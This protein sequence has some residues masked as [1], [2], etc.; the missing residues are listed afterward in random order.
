MEVVSDMQAYGIYKRLKEL[1]K[2]VPEDMSVIG[3]DDNVYSSLL[4]KPLTTIHQPLEE[5]ADKTV[6]T[7]LGMIEGK[8][9]AT[10]E[11]IPASLVERESVKQL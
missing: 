2:K 8:R 3:F 5:L 7:M 6:E 4:D 10:T 11:K 9:Y 1:G